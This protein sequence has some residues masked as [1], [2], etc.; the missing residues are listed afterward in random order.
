MKKPSAKFYE[1][2]VDKELLWK[3]IRFL[4]S[5]SDTFLYPIKK[6][7]NLIDGIIELLSTIHD[8]TEDK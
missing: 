4:D 5:V 6:E 2:I 1:L 7:L 8:Q 3:Q